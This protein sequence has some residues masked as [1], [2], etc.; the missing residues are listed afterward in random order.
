VSGDDVALA[1]AR[2]RRQ[3]LAAVR[4]VLAS[5][6]RGAP[7]NAPGRSQLTYVGGLARARRIVEGLYRQAALAEEDLVLGADSAGCTP[8]PEP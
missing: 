3:A 6:L 4:A 7:Y 2:G 5:E 8:A 1:A